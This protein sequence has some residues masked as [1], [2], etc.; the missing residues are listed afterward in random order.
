MGG[1]GP[2]CAPPL[3]HPVPAG[4]RAVAVSV[5]VEPSIAAG[6]SLGAV[7]VE[8]DGSVFAGGTLWPESPWALGGG[9]Q[10]HTIAPPPQMGDVRPTVTPAARAAAAESLAAELLGVASLPKDAG[11]HR[12]LDASPCVLAMLPSLPRRVVAVHVL[13][14][15][16]ARG[17]SGSSSGPIS[18]TA[19][20]SVRPV[21]ELGCP[22]DAVAQQT[23]HDVDVSAPD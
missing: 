18:S 21:V 17:G 5:D 14:C 8:A 3:R 16:S 19:T 23:S 1:V 2:G 10:S 15:R 22:P 13:L 6:V 9:L 20:V 4:V 7:A 11:A 12:P